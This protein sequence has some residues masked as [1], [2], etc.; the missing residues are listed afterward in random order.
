VIAVTW[1]QELGRRLLILLRGRQLDA[2]LEEEMRLH[3]ELREQQQ[4]EAGLSPEEAHSAVR[5]RFGNPLL[6]REESRDLWRWSWLENT[7]QDL[8]HGSRMLVKNPGFTAV[9]MITLALGIGANTAIFSVVNAVL[10]RPLPFKSPSSLVALHEGIP[11]MGYPK[12]GF[13]PPDFVI[14]GRE[15]RSFSAIGGF[16]NVGVEISGQGEPE[17][18]TAA[19]VSASLFR[20]LDAKP[21]LGRT[22]APEEDG[23]GHYVAILSYEL[24]QRRYGGEADVIGRTIE[25]DRQ[26]HTVIGV[27]PRDF[28]FPL[29][30]PTENGSPAALWV[31]MAFTPAELQGWGGSYFYSLVGRLKP[32]V[33]L[34]QA[35]SE[36]ESLSRAIAA[37]YPGPIADAIRRWRL[38]IVA[39]PFQEEVVG[40]IR[41]LLFVLTAAVAFVL[42]IACANVAMLLL[43]R[44]ASRHQEIAV[45]S[46]L[47]ATRL[48][49]I[50]Q[51]LIESLLLSIGG[52][53]LGFALAFWGR[54]LILAFAPASVPLPRQ[55]PIPGVVLAF[56]LAVAVL[57]ALL[58]GLAP[59]FQASSPIIQ[60]P[61]QEGGWRGTTDRSHLQGF[62]VTAEFCLALILLAG[63]GLLIHSFANLLETN[64][65]FR[66]DHVLT[67]N[68]PLP[69]QAYPHALQVQDF[70]QQ[71]LDRVSSLPGVQAAAVS[72]DLP[73]NASE[74]VS[75]SVE[76]GEGRNQTPQGIC[77]SWVLGDYL[78][79]MGIPLLRGRTFGPED[80]LETQPVAIVSL[81]F[82]GKFW[83]GQNP[84]GKRIRWGVRDP[85]TMVVGVAGDV[86]QGPFSSPLAPHVYRPYSQLPASF[87]END[88]FGDWQAMNLT[89][90]TQAEPSSMTS[91]VL[92]RVHS[93]DPGLAVT[94]VS[95]MTQVISS[96]FAGAKFNA[97]LVGTFAGLALF[98]AAIGVYGVL[99]YAVA[100]RSHEIGIRMALGATRKGVLRLVVGRG[101]KL[102]LIG[103]AVGI[104]GSL[105]LTRFLVSL[106]Y[107]VKPTDPLTIVAV[108]LTL[109]AVALLASYIPARRATKVNPIVALRWE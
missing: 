95:T 44:A 13:S 98:L 103:V 77:Q 65:G 54:D 60:K 8:R 9:A 80:R 88:P 39:E 32:G 11:G 49:L 1:L 56:A 97:I 37:S 38:T 10:L 48:R 74:M 90:R 101:L 69:R 66:P 75:I 21:M 5:R 31:P 40:S 52:G 62:F 15:Q 7:V 84:I 86:N 12:V 87:L 33:T 61:L 53:V 96:S 20:L 47:G 93:L 67:L 34:V 36:A 50:S 35:R 22:F 3:R 27:M 89:L 81:S 18:A 79:T 16:R 41:P 4:I 14:F 2:D 82:T 17:R 63:A 68:I 64:P 30:G 83:P 100:R 55:V 58:F 28:K 25:L 43:S 108:S 102:A 109:T 29:L 42:L 107:G 71:L 94:N 46:A 70:Y 91:A 85:W 104:G 19:R 6:L 24:W 23:E 59:A 92:A 105:L 78:R 76:E 45:R 73:L 106:L 51:M 99:A 72:S 26:P 57:A